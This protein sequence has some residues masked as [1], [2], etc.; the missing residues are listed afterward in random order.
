MKDFTLFIQN[1]REPLQ[2]YLFLND[3]MGYWCCINLFL[4]NL[5]IT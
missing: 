2:H 1:H 4:K 3:F 5:A